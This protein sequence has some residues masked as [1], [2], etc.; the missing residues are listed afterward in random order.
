VLAVRLGRVIF[1]NIRR[2]V[3]YSISCNISEILVVFFASLADITLPIRPLQI[4]YLNLVT[5]VFPALALGVGKG[6]YAVME[7]QPRDAGEPV[8]TRRHWAQIGVYSLLMTVVVLSAF[9]LA[10]SWLDMPVEKTITISFFTLALSQLWHVFNMRQ[11]RSSIYNNDVVRNPYVWG[12]IFL[13]ILLLLAAVYIPFLAN[14][15]GLA[16]PGLPG[17][18]LIIAMSLIPL[19]VGQVSKHV[20]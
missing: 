5:D 13:S 17:W 18:S 10:G 8:L 11:H 7:R 3:F 12:A 20:G 6:D 19:A 16:A 14:V 9:G 4:L 2:F 1:N 15:L